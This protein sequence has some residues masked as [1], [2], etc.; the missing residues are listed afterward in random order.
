MNAEI[1]VE[2]DRPQDSALS[3]R[4]QSN[5]FEELAQAD[6]I[7]K[8]I[9]LYFFLLIFEG[10]LRK[11]IFPQLATPLLVVRDPVAIWLLITAWRNGKFP[12]NWYI[13]GIYIISVLAVFTALTLGHGNLYVAIYGARIFLFHF[14]LMFI[15]GRSFSKEDVVK[16]GKVILW[17]SIPM[18]LLIAVQFNSPQSALVNRGI[19]GDLE[20]GGFSGALG[21]YRPPG[22]FSFTS[23][24]SQFFCLVALFVIYFWLDSKGVNRILLIASTV[25]VIAAVPLS[26]SRTLIFQITVSLAF[27]GFSIVRN[28]KLLGRL[29]LT[30]SG[31]FIVVLLLNNF[32]FFQTATAALTTRLD[33]AGETEG[34]L[35]GTLGDRFLGGLISAVEATGQPFFGYGIG[36]GTNA[37]AKLLVGGDVEFLIAE[38]EWARLVGEMGTIMGLSV[39]FIRVHLCIKMGIESFKRLALNDILPWILLSWGFVT[40]AQ[41]QW[42]QPTTLGFSTLIGGLILALLIDKPGNELKSNKSTG[43]KSAYTRAKNDQK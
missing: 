35:K 30:I 8:G 4:K 19:G 28:P 15:I 40:I 22:T 6:N 29:V 42:A 1:T 43:K 7:K 17:L 20:G 23:G 24:N 36:M 34:G 26:I 37:G 41:S 2:A 10:A 32:K 16:M 38:E 11:W 33:D 14:P 21:F 5:F 3:K 31:L 18:V 39:I 9:W 27:T 13:S 25:A 12:S